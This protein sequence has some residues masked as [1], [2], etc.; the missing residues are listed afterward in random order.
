MGELEGGVW[1]CCWTLDDLDSGDV[2]CTSVE[3]FPDPLEL[4]VFLPVDFDP[5]VDPEVDPEAEIKIIIIL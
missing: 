3:L 2:P 4:S 1:W 5:E